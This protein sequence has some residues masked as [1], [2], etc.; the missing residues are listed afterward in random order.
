MDEL[1][2]DGDRQGA[3]GRR[4]H[5]LGGG[6]RQ[7]RA[8]PL[9]AREEQVS[10]G[11]VQR[12]GLRPGRR[13]RGVERAL[14]GGH[15]LEQIRP[16]IHYSPSSGSSN[17]RATQLSPSRTSTSMRRSASRELLRTATGER[18]A[19]LEGAQRVLQL[20]LSLLE[21]IHDRL[22]LLERGLEGG[23]IGGRVR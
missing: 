15:A 12:R 20:E 11:R 18:D 8:Q 7:R 23:P 3:L 19:G 13:Q 4:A 2:G 6:E 1:D 17:G 5:R 22:E 10:H 9:A 14:D 16:Q 21:P